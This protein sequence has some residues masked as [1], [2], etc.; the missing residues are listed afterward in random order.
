MIQG[1][2]M[3][4]ITTIPK[5]ILAVGIFSIFGGCTTLVTSHME[6]TTPGMTVA[7]RGYTPTEIPREQDLSSKS[8]SQYE[9]VATASDGKKMYGLLPL[10]VNGKTMTLS[11]LFFAPALAIGGFRD[12]FPF[13]QFYIEKNE[14]N[15]K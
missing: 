6:G 14:L 12:A 11:I 7:V 5:F 9:F 2:F 13:Y 10:R 3:S 15:Y 4:S 8:T 1:N